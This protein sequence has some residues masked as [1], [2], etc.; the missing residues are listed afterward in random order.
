MGSPSW[1]IITRHVLPNAVGTIVVNSTFQVADA[2]LTIAYLSFLGLGIPP[3]AATWGGVLFD[4]INY[5]YQGDWWLIY[6]PG[7][8]ILLTVV[9]FNY[10]G[11]ATRDA[12]DLRFQRTRR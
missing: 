10:L 12:F 11:D 3:P 6:F 4:G 5:I 9:A 2:I 1:R 7:I 8:A